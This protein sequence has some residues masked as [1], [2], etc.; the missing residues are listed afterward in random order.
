MGV[1]GQPTPPGD[2]PLYADLGTEWNDVLS[3]FPEDRRAEF[4]PKIHEKIRAYEPLKEYEDFHRS[5]IK[6]DQI[7]T[8]LSIQHYIE[9]NPRE[10]YD[11]IGEFLGITPQEVKQLTEEIKEEK[12]SGNTDPRLDALQEK[13]DTLARIMLAQRQEQENSSLA[14][15]QDKAVEEELNGIKK[16]YGDDIPEDEILMRM[17]HKDMTAEQAYQDYSNHVSE[18]QKRRPAPYVMGSGGAV[19]RQPIDVKKLSGPE[20]K[21]IVAQMLTHANQARQD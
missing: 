19:P 16:K 9:N 10:V 4:A 8:A 20:T 6:S 21:N 13:F 11:R 3:G 18:I 14:A 5:G 15:Q 17:L 1:E 12:E 2:I 7:G